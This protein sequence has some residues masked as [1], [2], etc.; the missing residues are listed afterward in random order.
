MMSSPSSFG[1]LRIFTLAVVVT[2]PDFSSGA[3]LASPAFM[4]LA[5]TQPV[6]PP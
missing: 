5:D 4:Y 2:L 3:L 6:L 1:S